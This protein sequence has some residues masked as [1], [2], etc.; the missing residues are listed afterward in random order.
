MKNLRSKYGP[1][2]LI[3]A[4]MGGAY[5]SFLLSNRT[6]EEPRQLSGNLQAV[7]VRVAGE[8]AGQITA[9]LVD[10]GDRVQ[11]GDILVCLTNDSLQ[12]QLAQAETDLAKAQTDYILLAASPMADQRQAAIATSQ[13]DLLHAQQVLNDLMENA[14]VSRAIAGQEL[15]NMAQAL[16]NILDTDLQQAHSL[17]ALERANKSL[18]DAKRNLSIMTTPPSQ[19]VIS[20]AYANQLLAGS[21]LADTNEDI[22]LTQQKLKGGLGPYVPQHYVN[23]YKDQLRDLIKILETKQAR[24]QLAFNQAVEKYGRLLDPVDLLDLSIAEADLSMAAAQLKQAE[25]EYKRIV[26]GPNSADVAVLEAHIQTASREVAAHQQGPDPD[27]LAL[28]Q[29]KVKVAEAKLTLA[30]ADTIQEELEVA[31]AAVT[32]AQAA[33]NILRTQVDQLVITAPANGVVLV[34]DVEPGE[35]YQP[36]STAII[37]GSVGHLTINLYV[38]ESYYDHIGVGDRVGF[39]VNSYPDVVYSA[40]V[41]RVAG[42]SEFVSRN[43]GNPDGSYENMFAV[44]LTVQDP[45][46]LLKPGMVILLS[47]KYQ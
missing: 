6:G 31:Q 33:V 23:D 36:G 9:V 26:N 35:G 38:P 18:N 15:E 21:S 14:A 29:A 47:L 3:L 39:I 30:S 17:A 40:S 25:R 37:L 45:D 11:A 20:Q 43:V 13:K 4:V 10:E 8:T 42:D 44:E 12:A 22:A 19:Y 5:L 1:F 34:R 46:Y 41:A 24:E 16:E 27:A 28:A 2:I 7:E 32:V